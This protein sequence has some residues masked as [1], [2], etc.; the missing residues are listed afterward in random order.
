MQRAHEEAVEKQLAKVT[1]QIDALRHD[2]S[3][4]LLSAAPATA[5]T[6]TAPARGPTP[7][8]TPLTEESQFTSQNKVKAARFLSKW[9]SQE[10]YGM[11]AGGASSLAKTERMAT[12]ALEA[13]SSPPSCIILPTSRIRFI[14]DLI[15]C[16]LSA[17]H[18][19]CGSRR[20]RHSSRRHSSRRSSSSRSSSRRRLR[21]SLRLC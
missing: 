19:R 13:E 2:V 21:A 10:V 18:H 15:T 9:Q 20:R 5:P 11:Q 8:A 3:G 4:R 6:S 7:L 1:E 14:W 12:A 17:R 16:L